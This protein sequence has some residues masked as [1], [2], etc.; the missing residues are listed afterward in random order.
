M[1]IKHVIIIALIALLLAG[2]AFAGGVYYQKS[3]DGGTA[4]AAGKAGASGGMPTG[5]PM[6]QLSEEEQAKVAE[7]TDE[8]RQAYFQEKMGDRAGRTGVPGGPAG[9]FVTAEVIEVAGDTIT[10]KLESGSSQ[11]YYT[12]GDTTV[13]YVKGAGS[14]AAGSK[15]DVFAE[16]ETDGVTTIKAMIVH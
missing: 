11:T 12:D 14:L 4:T 6:G 9:G 8:E 2:G 13:G 5:G 7:M 10:V 3:R 1:K 16:P 15:I